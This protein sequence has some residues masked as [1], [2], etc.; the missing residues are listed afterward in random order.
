MCICLQHVQNPVPSVGNYF[1]AASSVPG[2]RLLG[3]AIYVHN[4]ITYDTITVNADILQ[5]SAIVLCLPDNKKLTI[6][7][8]YNQPSESYDLGQI[9]NILNQFQQ[10]LLIV[11]DF[12]AHHPL[13]DSNVTQS[14]IP[15]DQ[16]ES[17]I[18]NHNYCCLNEENSSTYASRSHGTMSS[19]DLSICSSNIVDQFTWIVLDDLYTSDHF[20]IVLE[21]LQDHPTPTIPKFNLEKADWDRFDNLTKQIDQF[22]DRKDHNET[23]TYFTEFVINAAKESI[24]MCKN[25]PHKRTVPWWNDELSDLVKEK[26]FLGRQLD[27]LKRRLRYFLRNEFSL[28]R[29][30]SLSIEIDCLKPQ[31]NRV[32]ALFRKKVIENRRNSWNTYITNLSDNTNQKQ[33]WHR[34][35]KVNGSH[36]RT[37]RSPL[38]HNG[39]RIHSRQDISNIIGRHLES[40]GNSLNL[41]EHFRR[42]KANAEKVILNFETRQELTYNSLF[43]AVELEAALSSCENSAPGK[44]MVSFE[45]LKHINIRAKVYLLTFYNHLWKRGL[46]P[47]AWR[48]AI[49]IPIAKPGKDPSQVTNYRP[50]SLTSCL[51][52]LMEKMV[53]CRLMWYVERN[54]ML[55]SSQS[56]VRKNRSTLDSLAS[57]ESEIKSGFKKKEVTVAVF[58]DIHKAFDTTWRYSILKTL[59][60]NHMRG[61]LPIFIKNFLTERTFQTRIDA[62]YSDSFDL[63]EGVPQ[64]SVL[65]GTL[66]VLAIDGIIKV[67][68]KSVKNSLFELIP[69]TQIHSI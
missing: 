68:P 63:I 31:L 3:T 1:L 14:D 67:L 2:D 35:R 32:S 40:V 5:I 28:F 9:P 46:F 18:E 50:I 64:G 52:K 30:V 17:L 44:D 66:F 60:D 47:K 19:I 21:Y 26:H 49:V 29:A 45:L 6:C 62:T 12:N 8:L 48:H 33:L 53:N 20:P 55:S 25:I 15:G 10:P 37:P 24:P 4:Q 39:L 61:E 16:I 43:T 41:D 22:N 58:F 27:K 69:H 54:N 23:N 34:F 59:H 36:I 7:N 65:S 57:L 38:S 42:K 11:G 51:C 13:W 56:G